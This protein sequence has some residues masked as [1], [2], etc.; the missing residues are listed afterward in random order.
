MRSGVQDQPGQDGETL[1]LLKIQKLARR[2]SHFVV[3]AGVQWHN[4]Y[5]LQPWPSRLPSSCDHRHVPP[6]SAKFFFFFLVETGSHFV[7][8]AFLKL[9]ISSNPPVSAFQSVRIISLS[10]C[11]RPE[12]IYTQSYLSDRINKAGRQNETLSLEKKEFNNPALLPRLE[13]SGVILPLCNLFLLGSSDSRASASGCAPPHP[14]NFCIFSQDRVSP[15]WLGWPQAPSLNRSAY[16][17]LPNDPSASASRVAGTV[18]AQQHAWLILKVSVDMESSH[19]AQAGLELLGSSRFPTLASQ[20]AG[21]TGM[22]QHVWLNH[23]A[24]L[25]CEN[26]AVLH[27][28]ECS[29]IILAYCSLCLWVQVILLPEPPE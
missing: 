15:C 22:S 11:T 2:G 16:F 25:F 29:V 6:H 1:S 27:R 7:A 26:L 24:W 10:N 19:V 9:L 8:E 12:P 18:G 14:A 17:G 28:P 13:C 23:G 20:S 21:V 5:S 4:H 3:Q